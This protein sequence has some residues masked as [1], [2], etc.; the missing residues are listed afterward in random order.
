MGG[1]KIVLTGRPGVG[2]TCAIRRTVSLLAGLRVVGFYT[3]ELRGPHGRLGFEAV[4]LE[5]RK[6]TLA[7]VDFPGPQ[8]VSRYGVDVEGFEQEIVPS[9][10]AAAQSSADLIVIDEIGKMECFSMAFRDGVRLALDG[11][12]PVLCTVAKM[13]G[14]FMAQVR[15]RPDVEMIEVTLTNRDEIPVQ[16]AARLRSDIRTEQGAEQ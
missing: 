9:I 6:L 1:P 15:A 4:T 8:R 16:V 12:V 3:T 5:G 13:G 11:P 10:G 7:R 2:K 14:G